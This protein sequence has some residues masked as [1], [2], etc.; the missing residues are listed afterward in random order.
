MESPTDPR[1][2]DGQPRNDLQHTLIEQTL[3]EQSGGDRHPAL[4]EQLTAEIER[5]QPAGQAEPMAEFARQFYDKFPL[6]ELHGRALS[7]LYAS[8]SGG[9]HFLQNYDASRPKVQ[10]F[11]PEF[12]RHGWQL[13]HTV[14]A[15]LCRDM[16]FALDSVR[17]ELNSRNITIITIH[18]ASLRVQR[19]ERHRLL[20]LLPHNGGTAAAD[21]TTEAFI[22]IEINRHSNPDDLAQ[23]QQAILQVLAEVECVVDDFGPMRARAAEVRRQLP[24]GAGNGNGSDAKRAAMEEVGRF[25]DWLLDDNFTFLGY[26]YLQV[27]YA[28]EQLRVEPAAAAA[29]GLLRG[30]HTVSESD[31]RAELA[32]A[33]A[34]NSPSRQLRFSKS[35]LRTRVHRRVYP[36]YVDVRVFD[37]SGR[38][39]GEHRFMGLYTSRVYTMPPAQIPV[40]GKKVEAVLARADFPVGSH[41][42]SELARV[43]DVHPRDELFHASTEELYATALGIHQIQE[44]RVVRLFVR[45]DSQAKYVSCLVFMPRDTYN[46]E[47]RSRIQALLCDVFGARE[48]EFSTF[49]S[50]SILTRTHFILQLDPAHPRESPRASDT[51]A[52]QD[53]I[54]QICMGWHDH[55]RNYLV[56][57]FGEEQGLAIARE[58][59]AAFPP[60]YRAEYDPRAAVADIRKMAELHADGD[61]AQRLYR[62]VGGGGETLRFRLYRRHCALALSDVM[63]ILEN[64][65]LRVLGEH[66]YAVRRRDDTQLWIHEFIL[67][68]PGDANVDVLEVRENFQEAFARIW[69][70]DADNDAFNRLV[71]GSGLGWR[72]IAMLRAYARF[73]K[74]IQFGFA[75]EYIAEALVKHLA[76][77]QLLVQLFQ[78]RF[79]PALARSLDERA[80]REQQLETRIVAALDGVDNLSEDRIVRQYVALLKA[81]LR[82]NYYQ[83]E[84]TGQRD[85]QGKPKNYVAFKLDSARVP[86]MPQPRPLYEI[87]VHSPRVE[88]V[89]LR[90]SKVARGGLR[91]SD[92]LEDFRTEVLGLVKAQNVKNA[93]IVPTGAKGGFVVRRPAG[94]DREAVQQE[95][96][97]CYRTFVSALLDLTDNSSADG[98]QPAPQV[99]RHDGDDVYLV[100]AADKGTASFSDIA[101]EIA[102]QHGFW[103]GDA[104][105]SG[106]SVGYDHK[107]M[108]IT[109]RG[110][111]ISVRRHFR[112]M[113][114]DVQNADF[115]VVGIG[116]MAGDV[117]GNGMLMSR[118]IRLVAAF[119]HQHIFIDPEPDAERS[120]QERERLFGLPRSSWEDYDRALI[121]AGGGIFKR[122]AKSIAISPQLRALLDIEAE[123]LAPNELIAAL[124]KAPIDLLW[125]GGIGTYVKARGQSH[126][127]CGDKANDAVRVDGAD[128]RCKVIGEGGNLGCTQPGRIEYALQGGRCNTDFID[129][130]AGVDC[131]DHEVNIK[132]ALNALVAAGDMTEKQRRELLRA[133]TDAVGELVL[134]H[135]YRQTLALSLAERQ[136]L[137]RSGEYE[138]LIRHMESSGWLQRALE[139]IPTDDALVERKA[140]GSGLTR[141]ELAV[142]ISYTK[143]QLKAA[144]AVPAIADDPL[145]ERALFSAFPAVLCESYRPALERHRLRTQIIGTK[146]ANDM[147]DLM[148]ITFVERISQSTGANVVDVARAF[149]TAREVFDLHTWWQR[150]EALDDR[151]DAALQLDMMAVVTRLVRRATRWFIRN[152]RVHLQPLRE[153]ERFRAPIAELYAQY[154]DIL[155]GRVLEDFS[156]RRQALL[157]ARVP[158]ELATYVAT[159]HF[160]YPALSIIDAAT[161][162]NVPARKVAEVYMALSQALELDAFAKQIAE[163]KVENHWQAQARETFRDDLEWQQRKLAVG[164]LG[165]LCPQGDV[166]AC[167]QRWLQTQQPLV[168]RWRAL[169]T[170]LHG[171][172]AKE[173]AVFAVAIRELLDLAQS[174]YHGAVV[175]NTA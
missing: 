38:I 127:E 12:D 94:G 68:Y 44:R 56:E 132:I 76:I 85:A 163:L 146:V 89:H 159:A 168:E 13:P 97:E 17:G 27:H 19:D 113:G 125:N 83:Y 75:S 14:V 78:A 115:S 134:R 8:A 60:G 47:L 58:Y 11:N 87:F 15:L 161:E 99:V 173:F 2:S 45:R 147:V 120:F 62:V 65:G 124:L 55:L 117:F 112:E 171:T 170:E 96:I 111:W 101:N 34:D 100:V 98:T 90:T 165:H 21:T 18:S 140:V 61:I 152:R 5:R 77:T 151:V 59:D 137:A 144:L 3:R 72:A 153:V 81:T 105:A 1:Q 126:A 131:S 23:L 26:E 9:W 164:A 175:A 136:A 130:S 30:A 69:H 80:A 116:D 148:G 93:V 133:M 7:D 139:F 129:N 32:T 28:G 155:A 149:V 10:I 41:E 88:G 103:L 174:T 138:R 36:D 43:L 4:I 102:A 16:P 158:D 82:T 57:E 64:L 49:F 67:T 118:H 123:Q 166:Q 143:A 145:L 108:G 52:L 150:I 24:A 106:G 25:I 154:P 135:N 172:D 157:E 169:L 86:D 63:P 37:A 92:R 160:L 40:L 39:Q 162:L 6:Q 119:N 20:R 42:R 31:L 29:Y 142:L 141:P 73:L 107:K 51:A 91:W 109:A 70:G 66:S 35:S 95:G 22:Y 84:P 33:P 79:D 128:L 110:A 104:F 156:A 46:T 53:D 54:V 167:I 48:A 114:I 50:E 71:P 74:Q 121:S 122:S